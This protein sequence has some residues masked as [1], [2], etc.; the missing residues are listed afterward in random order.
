MSIFAKTREF[1]CSL[2][3]ATRLRPTA[4][5]DKPRRFVAA[6]TPSP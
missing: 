2:F 4:L 6:P 5:G 3:P 1:L